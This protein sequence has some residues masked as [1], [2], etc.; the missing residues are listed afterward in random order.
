M[1]YA[2]LNGQNIWYEHTGGGGPAVVWSHGF[3][4]DREM[5][6]PNIAA[7]APRYRSIAWD[8]RGF[9]RTGPAS[10]PLYLSAATSMASWAK[11]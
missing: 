6:A 1:P 7:L 3:L 11:R 8:E 2:P 5:F 9:G 4:M 10:G